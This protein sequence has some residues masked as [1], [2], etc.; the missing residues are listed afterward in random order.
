MPDTHLPT[1][2]SKSD[3]H[4]SPRNEVPRHFPS[5]QVPDAQSLPSPHEVPFRAPSAGMHTPTLEH[6]S[7]TQSSAVEQ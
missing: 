2:Q 1:L 4:G 3:E 6:F 7:D 5:R